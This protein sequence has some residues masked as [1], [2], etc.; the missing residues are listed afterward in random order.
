MKQPQLPITQ[1]QAR[2]TPSSAP[3][4]PA[5]PSQVLAQPWSGQKWMILFFLLTFST[6]AY[7]Q[8]FEGPLYPSTTYGKYSSGTTAWER[9]IDAM[10]EDG[11]STR[12][13]VTST[14]TG[15]HLYAQDFGFNIPAGAVI[16]GI[17]A[18]FKVSSSNGTITDQS[19]RVIK[20]NTF[21]RNN[22]AR[23]SGNWPVS[24][25]TYLAYGGA[26][27]LW[28]TTWTSEDINHSSFGVAIAAGTTSAGDSA[29]VDAIRVTVY[30]TPKWY[31]SKPTGDLSLTSTWGSNPDGTGAQPPG[32]SSDD[33]T[34]YVTNR[35]FTTLTNNWTV[36]GK[37]SKVV[38]GDGVAAT[39]LTL[40]KTFILTGVLDVNSNSEVRIEHLSVMPNLAEPS[41]NSTVTFAGTGNQTIPGRNYSTLQ[42]LGS[43]T[44]TLQSNASVSEGLVFS[45]GRARLDVAGQNLLLQEA[46]EIVGVSSSQY[47]L[48]SGT[49]LLQREVPNDDQ[50]YQFPVG[51]A[52]SFNPA[53]MQLS[54]TSTADV[55]GIRTYDNIYDNYSNGAPAG[56]QLGSDVVQQTWVANEQI[57]G[58]SD[59]TLFLQWNASEEGSTFDRTQSGVGYFTGG[60]YSKGG[61]TAAGGGS[62]ANSYLVG[63]TALTTFSNTVYGVGTIHSPVPVELSDFAALL[64]PER[65]QVTLTW[66]TASEE[67]NHYFEIQRSQDGRQWESIGRQRGQGTTF[68][69]HRYTFIDADLP[70]AS[71]GMLY[72][73]LRQVDFD[74]TAAFSPV[75]EV[76]L[77]EPQQLSVYPN[78]V[79]DGRLY[80]RLNSDEL[81]R[82]TSV[83]V[84]NLQGQIVRT[85][86]P[87]SQQVMV[88]MDG[89]PQG[90]Y[91]I[92][93]QQPQGTRVER[94]MLN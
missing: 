20:Q 51:S 10:V 27:D 81:A 63:R 48:T 82:Q 50:V 32:F 94:V 46:V 84:L 61:V 78:P 44:K 33:Q 70:R 68:Q 40:D 86:T 87:A 88:E 3:C 64:H 85:L 43:G 79:V 47:V 52:S 83:Q 15:D 37:N 36:S 56:A 31:Y 28:G 21:A 73:R 76:Q 42:I 80:I 19:V 60:T 24:P 66:E 69:R 49:G 30:Y 2:T 23:G 59:A 53:Y 9:P 92:R 12:A 17:V 6:G 5:P 77:K 54:T 67:N 72:Y 8:S 7:A 62:I 55:F 91:L 71:A 34:F 26:N 45:G 25:A 14:T 18:E 38:V 11:R 1:E 22:Y 39:T 35:S 29:K 4:P 41:V 16:D 74:G 75:E 58:G 13:Y 90:Q 89:L 65:Q 57:A 93:I